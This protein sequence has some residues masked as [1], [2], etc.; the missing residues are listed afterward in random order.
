MGIK[1]LDESQNY[2]DGDEKIYVSKTLSDK[3][4][5]KVNQVY[6]QTKIVYENNNY[7]SNISDAYLRVT[8]NDKVQ[9]GYA[10]VS[11][12]LNEQTSD[13]NC[14]GKTIKI[15]NENIYYK[16]NASLKID[17]AY[18]KNNFKEL[19]GIDNF[20][21]NNGSIFINIEDYNELFN[22]NSYQSSIIVE[23]V[24]KIY[25]TEQE[26][27]NMGIKSLIIKDV[28][29][30]SGENSLVQVVRTIITLLLV[31][32]L[33]FISYFI[34][35]IILRSRNIY[36]ATLRMLGANK[37]ISKELL[38]IELLVVSNLAYFGFILLLVLNFKGIINFSTLNTVIEYLKIKDYLLLYA[39]IISMS[40]AISLKYSNNLFKD[41][42][43]KTYNKE[44]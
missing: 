5:L 44:V 11:K 39:I 40:Y 34:I 23:N 1:Y 6:S 25:Q 7:D 36:F 19:L 37:K 42:S 17:K 32:T 4:Q 9:K 14:I 41:S 43:V 35:T 28:L 24:D 29:T 13:G 12:D 27:K 3:I 2:Y 10:Y 8:P 20:E 38:I 18:A 33:F 15:E 21:G 16:S 26:L 22:K 30:N 31:V